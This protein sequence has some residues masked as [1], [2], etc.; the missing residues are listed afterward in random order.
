MSVDQ[1]A[2]VCL[3]QAS[4]HIGFYEIDKKVIF[5]FETEEGDTVHIVNYVGN[6]GELVWAFSSQVDNMIFH[7]M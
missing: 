1:E 5:M 2:I 3:L 7:K 6:D 4:K